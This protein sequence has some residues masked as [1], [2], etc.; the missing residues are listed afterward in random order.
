MVVDH[1]R[2]V[3]R[4]VVRHYKGPSSKITLVSTT[5]VNGVTVKK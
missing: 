2:I 1:G 4:P 3:G 5:V